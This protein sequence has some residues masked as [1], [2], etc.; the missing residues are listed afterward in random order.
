MAGE[1]TLLRNHL[2]MTNE[3]ACCFICIRDFD[4]LQLELFSEEELLASPVSEF[5]GIENIGDRSRK[6]VLPSEWLE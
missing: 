5:L 6:F 1:P 4:F 3:T 2:F